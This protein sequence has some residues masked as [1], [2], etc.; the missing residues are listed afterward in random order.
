M[1]PRIGGNLCQKL[2]ADRVNELIF[3]AKGD[4]LRLTLNSTS[5]RGR[6]FE[7]SVEVAS[8]GFTGQIGEIHFF[9][10]DYEQF[11]RDLRELDRTRQGRARLEAMTPYKFWMEALSVDKLGHIHLQGK[12]T[13]VSSVRPK[14]LWNSL[15]FDIE[16]DPSVFPR[17]VQLFEKFPKVKKGGFELS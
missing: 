6:S 11:L 9:E 1:K 12:V 5:K 15:G 16:L 7:V 3:E 8:Q 2:N 13:R 17:Q 10:S 14:R 4:R